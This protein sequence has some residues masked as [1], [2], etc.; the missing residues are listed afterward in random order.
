MG[1][2]PHGNDGRGERSTS[3][4]ATDT[5]DGPGATEIDRR[6]ALRAGAAATGLSAGELTLARARTDGG[7]ER[8]DGSAS[9][10]CGDGTAQYAFDFDGAPVDDGSPAG[11]LDRNRAWTETLRDGYFAAVQDGQD[12]NAVSVC[13][14][15]ARVAQSAMFA[16]IVES[17]SLFTPS[18]IGNKVVTEVD[19]ER[20]VDGSFG[21]ALEHLDV[22][23]AAVVGHTACGAVTAAYRIATGDLDPAEEPPGVRAEVEPLVPIVEDG[24]ADGAVDDDAPAERAVN[25]LVEYNVHRQIDLLLDTGELPADA[26]ACGFVYD[27]VGAYSETPGRTMLVNVDGTSDTDALREA[28]PDRQAAFVGTLLD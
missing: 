28:L 18:N 10:G 7:E 9:E 22:E 3:D 21:Y 8:G 20:A 4:D 5:G 16:S 25:Q 27:F 1:T 12:P 14:S 11:L 23:T 26:T 2:M 6:T 17:G 24:L 19:G 15:D 13:C